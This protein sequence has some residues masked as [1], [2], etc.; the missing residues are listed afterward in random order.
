GNIELGTTAGTLTL[1][2]NSVV[3]AL[4][5]SQSGELRL[6]APA[7]AG[8]DVAI[9]T[10]PS[11]VSGV[12]QVV[13][14]P[15]M[16]PFQVS[17]AP[18]PADLNQINSTVG[19]YMSSAGANI[20]GR[21]G[22]S[23]APVLVQPGI[24]LQQA[25]D[26]TL[27]DPL[28]LSAWRFDGQ[29]AAL[30]VRAGGA[31]N[32]NGTIS[33]GFV[34]TR[35]GRSTRLSLL[36]QQSATLRFVAG[37]DLTS[38][39]PLATVTGAA[40][41]LTVGPNVA[42]RT[43]TGSIALR[44]SQN[45]IFGQG[46]TVFTAGLPGA[47]HKTFKATGRPSPPPFVFDFPTHGG[48]VSIVSGRDIVGSAVT[49][50]V[51]AWQPRQGNAKNP[52]QWG[53]D[54]AQFGWNAGAL[55]GGDLVLSA[56]HNILNITA[57]AADSRSVDASGAATA[58]GGGGL[59]VSAGHDVASGQ[60]FIAKGTGVLDAGGSFSVRRPDDTPSH[61]LVGSLLNIGDAQ[62]SI[63]ARGDITLEGALNPQ[64]L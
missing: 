27:T 20:R 1:A 41:D 34:T 22:T 56:G 14:E 63:T 12:G 33:D 52:A 47:A 55:G 32:I 21:L 64:A 6:R 23:G 45:V 39:D 62:V 40:A 53:V 50:S 60:F 37:A 29:P 19:A 54:L 24:E 26:L 8:S 30:T 44:A 3:S 61:D 36:D 49:Q 18:S 42:I 43:G 25:G 51:M 28:N 15:V 46:S 48:D 38:A 11:D 2:G 4:G 10:L 35:T 9:T 7:I 17:N 5:S 58:F 59:S 57:A 31:L 13:I 16:T